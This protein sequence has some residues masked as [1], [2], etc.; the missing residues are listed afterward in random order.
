M[1]ASPVDSSANGFL[2]RYLPSRQSPRPDA[3]QAENQQFRESFRSEL[4]DLNEHLTRSENRRPSPLREFRPQ[5]SQRAAVDSGGEL[6]KR[7]VTSTDTPPRP[8]QE[9][10]S[11]SSLHETSRIRSAAATGSSD[12]RSDT[13]EQH[14]ASTGQELA[15]S[16]ESNLYVAQAVAAI[17]QNATSVTPAECPGQAPSIAKGADTLNA[18]ALPPSSAATSGELAFAMRIKTNAD[19][20]SQAET[21][22][23][24]EN[25][26]RGVSAL[27]NTEPTAASLE[28]Q[29]RREPELAV[30]TIVREDGHSQSSS[31]ITPGRQPEDSKA[32][33]AD[34][35][36]ELR[37]FQAEPVRGAH[38]QIAGAGNQRVDIRLV[39]RAGALSVTVRSPDSSVTKALQDQ[40]SELTTRLS[41][42]HFRTELWTP[43]RHDSETQHS[44]EGN[45]Q[46]EGSE[47]SGDRGSGDRQ[48]NR[49]NPEPEWAQEIE[50]TSKTFK[51]RIEYL[52]HQ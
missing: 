12:K 10:P 49:R 16:D 27:L 7:R 15:D 42:E 46:R 34:F 31:E 8:H 9:R 52:W 20:N 19:S 2:A 3:S 18:D 25:S 51:K 48:Q 13:P 36:A 35:E 37:K 43:R 47:Q 22:Q 24:A 41:S 45:A 11:R 30:A 4:A 21:E 38:V 5:A 44:Q 1:N 29:Q 50:Q 6:S 40:V 23:V 26:D 17:P 32:T 39:E 33:V 28:S 14:D